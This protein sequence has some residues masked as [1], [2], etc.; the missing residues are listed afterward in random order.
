MGV[1]G[2]LK[3]LRSITKDIHINSLQKGLRFGIDA[4]CWLHKGCYQCSEALAYGEDTD[5]YV[6]Y[7]ISMIKMLQ[8]YGIMEIIVV[9]DGLPLEMKETTAK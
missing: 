7:F 4:H 1:S 6:S 3:C 9:F 2:L 8:S 5:V